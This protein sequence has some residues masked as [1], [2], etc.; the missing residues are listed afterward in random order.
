[1]Q[2]RSSPNIQTLHRLAKQASISDYRKLSKDALF[3]KLQEKFDMDRLLRTEARREKME[4]IR[5][6]KKRK[7]EET[8]CEDSARQNT[9]SPT[10][11]KSKRVKLN[12][13]DPIMLEPIGKKKQCFKFARPNGSVVR[14]NIESLV[15]YL[16]SA[17]EFCDPVTRIPFSDSDL[18]EMDAIARK[19]GLQKPSVLEAKRNTS[20]YTEAKFRRDALLALER[21]AGEVVTDILE[22]IETYDPDD[23][24]MQLVMR[25]FPAFLDYYRQLREADPA[26]A[27]KCNAH[28][29][30]FLQG[31]PNRPNRDECGLINV[32]VH[33]FRSCDQGHY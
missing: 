13:I 19:A 1:M 24:Q 17:G 30:L 20:A 21:C 14:F 9:S 28:W 18:T 2:T 15:D 29:R 7:N 3:V 10:A 27:S 11:S 16:L 31:P 26:Y 25:E 12:T 8:E 5:L 33:F 23:A 4:N 22:I 6:E 32:A